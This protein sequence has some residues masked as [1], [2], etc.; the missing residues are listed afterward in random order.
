MRLRGW[1]EEGEKELSNQR[2]WQKK[3]IL[4]KM[5]NT[6]TSECKLNEYNKILYD[7]I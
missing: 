3:K 2:M 1:T 7:E 4:S 5:S 6:L